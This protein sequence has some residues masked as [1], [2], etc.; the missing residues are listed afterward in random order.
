MA[1]FEIS[2]IKKLVILLELKMREKDQN[3]CEVYQESVKNFFSSVK[4]FY[5]EQNTLA[6]KE[7]NNY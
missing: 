7:M 2:V 3:M 4:S 1:D 6:Y 5:Q